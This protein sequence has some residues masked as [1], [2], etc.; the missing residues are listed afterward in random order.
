MWGMYC[1][2]VVYPT[3]SCWHVTGARACGGGS[4]RDN[5]LD[6]PVARVSTCS[7]NK[8]SELTCVCL[9]VLYT[10]VRMLDCVKTGNREGVRVHLAL[11]ANTAHCNERGQTGT[12][13]A[14]DRLLR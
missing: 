4:C 5:C 14:S 13:A 8:Q 1:T 2:G 9:T 12:S 11:G 3:A 7:P 6:Q 10:A